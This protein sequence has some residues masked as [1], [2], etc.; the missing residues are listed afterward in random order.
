MDI[1]KTEDLRKF[2]KLPKL[3]SSIEDITRFI[4]DHSDVNRYPVLLNL[5]KLRNSNALELTPTESEFYFYRLFEYIYDVYRVPNE[6]TFNKVIEW[7]D[8][9]ESRLV[10]SGMSG[11]IGWAYMS[12]KTNFNI[13]YETAKTLEIEYE[14]DYNNFYTDIPTRNS[15][16]YIRKGVK[17]QFWV[18]SSKY[19][20]QPVLV[21]DE[22]YMRVIVYDDHVYI[23]GC[24]D[25]AYG[26]KGD[27]VNKFV[28]YLKH[29]AP[30]WNFGYFEYEG[31]EVVN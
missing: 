10:Y 7:L 6:E 30:V 23:F 5:L 3:F 25:S 2:Y 19:S 24:D 8:G 15:D 21:G 14:G 11:V 1:D 16:Y 17:E 27:D 26:W 22:A 9:I 4:D 12:I 13:A 18:K 28:L 20:G 29:A 31:F